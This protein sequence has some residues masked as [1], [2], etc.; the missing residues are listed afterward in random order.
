[1]IN[2]WLFVQFPLVKNELPIVS[3]IIAARPEQQEIKAVIAAR[4]LDY[5][6]DKLEIIVARGCHPSVQRN[7]AIKEAKGEIIYFLDD[8]SVPHPKSLLTAIK[9]FENKNIAVVGGPNLCPPDAPF[10]EQVFAV[11][12]SSF[13][14]FGPSRARYSK[15]DGVRET[16]EK[17]LILCN[18]LIHKDLLLKFGGFD[19]NLY[20]NEENALMDEILANGYKLIYDPEFY[21]FRRP[22]KDLKSFIKMLLNYG[23]GRAEQFRLHP[24]AG[25]FLNLIPSLLCVYLMILIAL[26]ILQPSYTLFFSIPLLLY[27]V[28]VIGQTASLIPTFGFKKSLFAMPLLILT[29]LCYGLGFIKGL[30]TKP[31]PPVNEIIEGIKIEKI[32]G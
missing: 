27:L 2:Q 28:L 26:I 10:I 24:T 20:P 25:S 31:S 8:D 4:E 7:L 29:N 21:I 17:E 22:R 9:H 12:L 11:I 5:P 23:R 18:L 6:Q 1:L 13:L 32:A 3:I 19:T 15:V 16:T 30:F 14:A